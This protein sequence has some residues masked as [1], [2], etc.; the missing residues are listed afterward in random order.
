[1]RHKRKSRS[2]KPEMMHWWLLGDSA[3]NEAQ[4]LGSGELLP[5]VQEMWPQSHMKKI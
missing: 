4:N 3:S 5:L 1:M 2:Y